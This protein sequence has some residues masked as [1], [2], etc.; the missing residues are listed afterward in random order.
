M[1][2]TGQRLITVQEEEI[3]SFLK[4]NI[5][6]KICEVA[7]HFGLPHTHPVVTQT[8]SKHF[9]L[10]PA[11]HQLFDNLVWQLAQMI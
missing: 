2:V 8:V 7:A 5:I 6:R 3:L 4:Q 11:P 1:A 10:G 9:N